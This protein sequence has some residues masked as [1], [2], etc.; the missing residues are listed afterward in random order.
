P[1]FQSTAWF[2]LLAPGG[3]DPARLAQLSQAVKASLKDDSFVKSLE[4]EA[5]RPGDDTPEEFAR[6][7]QSE[8][9]RLRKLAQD[10]RI[11]F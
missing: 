4:A 6:F 8:I 9:P 7:I 1:G 10:A 2:G 5:G 11:Q 3:M